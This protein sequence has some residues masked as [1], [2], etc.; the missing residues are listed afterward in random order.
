MLLTRTGAVEGLDFLEDMNVI[1]LDDNFMG[2]DPS[3]HV[4]NVLLPYALLRRYPYKLRA[5]FA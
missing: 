5:I 3:A 2:P 1:A 4:T